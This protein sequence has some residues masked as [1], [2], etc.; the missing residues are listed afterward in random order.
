MNKQVIIGIDPGTILT[1]FAIVEVS[2]AGLILLDYGCIKPPAKFKLSERYRIIHESVAILLEKHHPDAMAIELQFVNKNP[3]STLKLGM[4]RGVIVLAATLN[5]I[6]VFEY[7]PKSAK[8]AVTGN[9]NASKYQVQVMIQKQFC[10]KSIPTPDDASDAIALAI[11][12]AHFSQTAKAI[13]AV[14]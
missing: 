2:L 7:S 1:G 11:C 6:A 3:Q 8:L 13:G 9:G 14:L 4:A 12:H 5:K 10:L